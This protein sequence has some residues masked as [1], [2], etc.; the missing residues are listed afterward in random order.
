MMQTDTFTML[1]TQGMHVFVYEWL[2]GPDD[3][4]RAIVQIAHG[5]CETGKR[6]EELAELLTEHGYAVYCNDHRGHGLTAGLTHLGDAGEDGFEGMIEDQLLLAAELKKRHDGVPHY[7]MGHSMGSFLTQKIICSDG[8]LFDGFILSGTNGPQGLLTFGMSLAAAQMRLQGNTHRSL[9]LNALVFGPYNKG[10][11][12][13]RTPFDWLSRDEAEVDKYINDPYCG[14]VC[15]A[16]FFRD[17]FKLLSQIHQ[18]QLMK[19]LP[20]DKPVY[21]FS[22]EDDPVGHRGKGVRRLIEL[23]RKHGVQDLEYR[24]YPG[25]RHEMLHETNR[26]DVAADVLDWL[27][28][29]TSG[30][31]NVPQESIRVM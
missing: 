22:G 3:P 11:G 8:E 1:N 7:L 18:P 19:C 10:F 25:G 17:F 6:Y 13:I 9:M 23:Y 27:E 29:H 28:R 5:M 24:L 2:P 12:P 26:A 30:S 16:R 4:V 31:D 21:I 14:K 20:K 15:T